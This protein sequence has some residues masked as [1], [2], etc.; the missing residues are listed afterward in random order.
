MLNI[1]LAVFFA[2]IAIAGLVF[3]VETGVFIGLALFPLQIIQATRNKKLSMF[4]I[5]IAFIPGVVFLYLSK[6]WL[7][8]FFFLVLQSY[9][10]WASINIKP[11]EIKS[12]K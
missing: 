11:K 8:L 9:N 4:I 3:A 2:I 10:Y 5:V 6:E 12:D 1:F 7:L